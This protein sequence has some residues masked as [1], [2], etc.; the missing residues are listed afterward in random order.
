VFVPARDTAQVT[1]GGKPAAQADGVKFLRMETGRAVFSL[2]SGTYRFS[3]P[4]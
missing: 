2:G 4:Q 1:E 3:A